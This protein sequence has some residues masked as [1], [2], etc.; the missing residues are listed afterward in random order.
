MK[1]NVKRWGSLAL[2]LLMATQ[3]VGIASAFAAETDQS[4]QLAI[5]E[6]VDSL[7]LQ[8]GETTAAINLN[9][10]A[11]AGTTSAQVKF[12]DTVVEA[13]V[14]PLTAPTKVD[15]SKY[16]DTGKIVCKATVDGLVPGTVYTYQI[17]NDG[18]NTWSQ[19]YTYT[20][21]EEDS[22]TF[23]FTS[24]PQIKENGGTDGAG[25]EPSDGANQTGWAK[26]MEVV[27]DAGAT[28]MVSA[29]DQVEDQSWGKS[30]EY[31][32][33]FAP[34]EMTSI[35]YA[36]AVGNHDRHY[37]FADH[38][39]LPNEMGVAEDGEEGTSSLL[40]QVKTT[41]RGQNSGTSQSHGN[42]IQATADEI[43]NQ[44]ESNGVTPNTDG[45]YDFTERREM[46]T[47]GNY[48]YL[49]NNVLF[50]TLNTGAYPGGN[51]EENAGS[52]SVPS[53]S[54][55]NSEAE[56]MVENFRRT[57]TAATDEYAGQY[58]WIIVTH[59]KSTQ[60]VAKHAADSDIENY[61]DA[62]F[63]A[64]MDEFNVDFVLGGHDH[65]Y[66][67]SYVLKDGERNAEALDT[68]YDPDGTIYLTGNCA[69]DMQYY[70]PFE[71]LDKNNN[72]DYPLLAN[73]ESGSAAYLEGNLPYGN[74]EYNQEYS[75]SYALFDVEGSTISVNVY[76]LNGGSENPDSELIDHFTVTKNTDGGDKTTG[77]EN[78]SVSLDLTKV[79]GYEA[80]EFNVDGGVMEIVSYNTV[81]G[82]AYAVNGQSGLLTAIALK[83][84]EEKD[85]VDLLDG[86]DIN[87][88]ALV[89]AADENF[90][91]GDMTSVAVSPD[92]KVLA[93]ALQAEGYADNGRVALF[94]CNADGSL[95]LQKLV[96]VGVQPDMVTFADNNTVLTADEGEPR[97]GYGQD[98]A[99]PKGSVSVVDVAAGTATVVTFDAFDAQRDQLVSAGIVLKKD[100]APSVDLEPEY[101][102][103]S[104]GN[105]Y[106]TIQE[107]NAIAV[108][109]LTSKTFTGI[110]S[111]GFEDYST[112]PVDIDK[113]DGAYGPKTYESLM[114]IRM[115]DG[116]AAFE[117]DGKTY[118]LTANEGDS[119]EW[120]DYL[121]EDERNFKDGDTS[122]TGA[123]TADN[124]GLT[125]K[126]VFF[127]AEDYDGLNSQKDY[128][129][130]GRSFTLY[131]V[132]DSG[133]QEVYTSGDDFESL[134]A[135]YLP[136]YFN[137][138]NDNAE[139]DDRSGKK[140]PEAES[141]TVGTVD[142]KIY[143]FIALERTGGVMVYDV[144]DPANVSYVNYINSRDFTFTVPGS[145]DEDKFVTGG[146]VA[147]EG[148]AFIPAGNSPTGKALLLT[149]CEVSGTVAVYELTSGTEVQPQP[150]DL[151]VAV[152]S[153]DHLYDADVLG[154]TGA[155]F[156]AYLAADR[157]M[158]VE[159]EVILDAAL[160][161]IAQGDAEYLLIPGDLT[162]DGEKVNHEL[163]AEKLAAFEEETEIQVFVINGNHDI[164][165][166]NAV[167]FVDDATEQVDT[168]D[169]N[170]FRSI[171][172]Q[173]GYDEAVAQD[174]NSLSYAVDLGDD[175]RLIVMD[176]G[177]YND[178]KENPSQETAGELDEET[179]DWVL[180]Q[181]QDAIRD[182]RRPIGMMHHGLVPHT[183]IQ[184]TMFPQYLVKDY[185][186]VADT[187][188]DAG[189]NLVFTGHF[190]SQDVSMT[191]TE[192]GN[193]L[194]DVET[195][196]L[197][198][199]PCPIRYVTLGEEKFSYSTDHITEVEDIDNFPAYA[200]EFLISGMEGLVETM[201]PAVLMQQNP[202]LTYEQATALA[203]QLANTELVPGSGI[204]VKSLLAGAF[205]AHYAGDEKMDESTAQIVA[206]LEAQ[207]GDNP[208]YQ[209]LVNTV[210]GL[211]TDFEPADCV[212]AEL[213]LTQL[214]DYPDEGGSSGS[215]SSGNKTETTTNPDGSTTTTVT[216]PDGSMTQTTK[217]PNGASSV[218]TTDKNGKVEAQVKLPAAVVNEAAEAG[219]TVALPMPAV[220][221]ADDSADAASITLDLPAGTTAK[222][223]IP[224]ADVTAGTVAVLMKADGTEEIIKTT[225]TT[226]TGVVVTL[227]DGDTVKIVDN[228]MDFTDV[229]DTHWGADTV[230]FVTSRQLFLGTGETTFSPEEHMTRAMIV[231]VLARYAGVDTSDGDSWYETG[232]QWAV[233]NGVSDGTALDSALS[234]EQLI[235]MLWRFAGSPAVEGG[236]S[237]Y[238]DSTSVSSWA[239][240]A[241]TWAVDTGIITGTGSGMLNPQGTA[242]RVEVAAVLA[243]FV[244]AVNQ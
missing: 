144:T 135:Q 156:E 58:D 59:H 30:S 120:E 136:K 48:Y 33:F 81:N 82:W 145:Q 24:D 237:D 13:E 201:L 5:L 234:R 118:L 11:P 80:G 191:T 170:D 43:A 76:N 32:A 240:Q 34:E 97:Q 68:Y 186:T 243:R 194:Y 216:R 57:L 73:G 47:K 197:V 131:E 171:Y 182:G 117:K 20:T 115:P 119:R 99:D 205:A 149:A 8:P 225:L 23:A 79:A 39:N 130:G 109:D 110:Y 173:F 184:P 84:L 17:S 94:T 100:T 90:A 207:S 3:T 189:M 40:E 98:I 242:T 49:Y 134:T 154:S 2:S 241:M 183:S 140:G 62:G 26:M 187:L 133:I 167:K 233:E 212:A 209:L 121:N 67:R 148:F 218:V 152:I 114:G 192:Q 63:E 244:E 232:A 143:A 78:G 50:V 96:T 89:E 106:V 228:S 142:G 7:T 72:A 54:K 150:D 9:W 231:T 64:L 227:A 16:T 52:D 155:A 45:I 158:L 124:S 215:G 175:Y 53:A 116:I 239:A 238:P 103:V 137:C 86:N 77:E 35:A 169:T 19:T 65:V 29:G 93:T 129:F 168:I 60:T 108:L 132:T 178:D 185:E 162:K 159:S 206:G 27:A 223:E 181:I 111:A 229:P 42:Y 10:Y 25:W 176:S 141:V 37:M 174:N 157:K 56:A 107:A 153:D 179:L 38:F 91:Y 235:T 88:K 203:Q 105:A 6:K 160:D 146:D 177:I 180:E 75:P 41:F 139:V 70:T 123:I 66:S 14:S 12:G 195:G 55:D 22:F 222:V 44:S 15:E 36:P 208:I 28:L 172:A 128:L 226:E 113:K 213:P 202:E 199:S 122:P 101:I 21:P 126:V 219:E 51:D 166:A 224:V 211:Y 74:Q 200:G 164:S 161:K 71:K 46:E 147:P 138:S 4:Q 193:V 95:T 61:V 127:L 85:T 221:A 217:A 163:L 210:K 31:E 188:A 102:A 204:T 18:G 236:L 151:K 104:G 1:L 214:P 92:G 165:N 196:S 220:A 87:V 125:G 69:S 83:T 112:T 190:H 198:T 230:A